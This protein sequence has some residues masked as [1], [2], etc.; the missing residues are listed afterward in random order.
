MSC[1]RG[2]CSVR[3][4]IVG[5]FNEKSSLTHWLTR[6]TA[7]AQAATMC[8]EVVGPS[9][10]RDVAHFRPSFYTPVSLALGG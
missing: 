4:G 6:N 7:C 3:I 1:L 8:T 10:R 9:V 5:I 2:T